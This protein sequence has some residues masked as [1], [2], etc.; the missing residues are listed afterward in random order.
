MLPAHALKHAEEC[1]VSSDV[2]FSIG[3]SAEVYP[4]ALMPVIA[5]RAG[6]YVAE[7]NINPTALSH[8]IDEVIS[9]KSGEVLDLLLKKLK[10][11]KKQN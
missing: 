4:A 3:T 2:F 8:D 7:I 5:K 11:L 6:A 9:G 1:A 10:D